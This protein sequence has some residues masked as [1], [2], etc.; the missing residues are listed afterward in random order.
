MVSMLY[1]FCSYILTSFSFILILSHVY[2]APNIRSIL[3][4][5]VKQVEMGNPT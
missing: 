1:T 2:W 5:M 3:Q 4:L